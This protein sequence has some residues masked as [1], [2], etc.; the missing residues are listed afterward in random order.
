MV[1]A[2]GS[3]RIVLERARRLVLSGWC[4]E[5]SALIMGHPAAPSVKS[6]CYCAGG[7]LWAVALDLYPAGSTQ[8]NGSGLLGRNSSSVYYFERIYNYSKIELTRTLHELFGEQYVDLA[9]YN[10]APE[11]T[12]EEIIGLFDKTIARLSV[13]DRKTI[14]KKCTSCGEKKTLDSFSFSDPARPQ[15]LHHRCKKCEEKVR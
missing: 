14:V 3:V 5:N 13:R 11:R 2:M 7:A 4:Q 6:S 8:R 1:T 15:Y 10:D 9:A 12:R